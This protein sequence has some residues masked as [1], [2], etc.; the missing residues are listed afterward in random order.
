MTDIKPIHSCFIQLNHIMYRLFWSN[1]FEEKLNE[2]L[3]S[4][5]DNP[6]QGKSWREIQAR[7]TMNLD[8]ILLN[9]S[10]LFEIHDTQLAKVLK[11]INN[12]EILKCLENIWNPIKEIKE[13]VELWRNN[14]V[15]HGKDQSVYFRTLMEIDPDYKNTIKKTYLASRLAV[16]YISTIF[17]NNLSDYHWVVSQHRLHVKVQGEWVLRDPHIYWK[18]MKTMEDALTKHSNEIL[19]KNGFTEISLPLNFLNP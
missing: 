15:A 13:K 1:I 2:E 11:E 17:I 8:Y 18:E 10:Q 4:L 19:R 6:D 5:G 16:K 3:M 9:L 14:Y 12:L 7:N